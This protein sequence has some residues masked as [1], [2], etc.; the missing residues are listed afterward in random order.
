MK[1]RFPDQTSDVSA[2][3]LFIVSVMTFSHSMYII[4]RC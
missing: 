4:L 2:Y 1:G 3:Y